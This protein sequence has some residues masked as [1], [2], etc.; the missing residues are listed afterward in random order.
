MLADARSHGMFLY[1][2]EIKYLTNKINK[3]KLILKSEYAT[4]KLE[5]SEKDMRELWKILNTLLGNQKK[6]IIM[7]DFLT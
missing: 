1:K 5:A 7:P 4:E 2:K 3:I 6:E